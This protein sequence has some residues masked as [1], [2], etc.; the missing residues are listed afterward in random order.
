[1]FYFII[2]LHGVSPKMT[3]LNYFRGHA[4]VYFFFNSV[5]L[6]KLIFKKKEKKIIDRSGQSGFA[7]V[8]LCA[9]T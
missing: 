2:F 6:Y 8:T 3:K 5:C 1:M 4:I 7:S 9:P